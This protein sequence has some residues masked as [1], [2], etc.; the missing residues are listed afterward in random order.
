MAV[1]AWL[2]GHS[3]TWLDIEGLSCLTIADW[4]WL[5]LAMVGLATHGWI[6]L[7]LAGPFHGWIRWSLLGL[8]AHDW[9][10]S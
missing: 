7:D 1:C 8:A 9:I 5:N 3:W 4:S 6:W 10:L 2:N